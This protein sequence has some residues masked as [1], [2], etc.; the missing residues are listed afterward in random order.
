MTKNGVRWVDEITHD[1]P[2]IHP[3]SQHMTEKQSYAFRKA[4]DRAEYIAALYDV[5]YRAHGFAPDMALKLT[6]ASLQGGH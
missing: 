1:I 3:A 5:L 6:M 4:H 2:A